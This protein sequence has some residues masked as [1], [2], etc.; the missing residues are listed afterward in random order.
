MSRIPGVSHGR[1]KIPCRHRQNFDSHF[2][3]VDFVNNPE[4]QRAA[5]NAFV[6]EV[7]MNE[8]PALFSNSDITSDTKVIIVNA[9]HL[10]SA[11][12]SAFNEENTKEEMFYNED[13][14][15]KEILTMSG[16]KEGQY[17]ENEEFQLAQLSFEDQGF[18]FL[19]MVP[20]I[21]TLEELKEKLFASNSVLSTTLSSTQKIPKIHI[22]IPKF[23]VEASY[24]LKDALQ[25]QGIIEVFEAGQAN[26]TGISEDPLNVSG[27]IHKS[28]FDLHEGGVKAAAA[29]AIV[30]VKCMMMPMDPEER[31]IKAE[32]PFLYGVTYNGAP[33]FVGQFY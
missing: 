24:D 31:T 26:L 10:A 4:I 7:T 11:F 17:F 18:S 32:K 20:K 21:G 25:R 19:F 15:T 23:K 5:L 14:S 27:V 3:K 8:I 13:G 28:V 9:M 33:L 2:E 22:S 1:G 6:K 12:M 30:A 29:T 16:T